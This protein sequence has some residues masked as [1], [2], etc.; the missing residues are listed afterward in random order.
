MAETAF[1]KYEDPRGKEAEITQYVQAGYMVRTRADADTKEARSGD[2]TRREAA[3]TSG[4]QIVST[5]YYRPDPRGGTT[6]GWT[7]YSVSLPGG[8]FAARPNPVNAPADVL[9]CDVLEQ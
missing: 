6:A 8:A 2:V 5:D 1:L 4:A 9:T 7:T 3:F